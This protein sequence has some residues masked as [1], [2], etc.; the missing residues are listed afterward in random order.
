MRRQW[1]VYT[2]W[3]AALAAGLVGGFLAG[4][5]VADT[6]SGA[7]SVAT[8]ADAGMMSGAY[9]VVF[10]R[11]YLCGVKTEEV[12][13]VPRS[14]VAQTL[15]A[16]QG[17]EIV[18][19]EPDKLILLKRENDL[20]PECKENGY[21]GISADGMLTLFHGLP[22]EAE[23]IQTFYRISTE[24]MEARLSPEE[25]A[26]LKKGIR[27]RDLAEYNSVLSTFGEFQIGAGDE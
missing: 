27:I 24:K 2:A 10:A 7:V 15:T 1:M 5:S 11:T 25:I 26:S 4:K 21:I 22:E 18:A 19:A 6:R 14:E 20:A 8:T 3:S 16:H 12:T 17:W 9:Q 23:V 13:K